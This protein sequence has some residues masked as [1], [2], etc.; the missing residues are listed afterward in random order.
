MIKT[1]II[2]TGLLPLLMIGCVTS[3]P[4]TGQT[5]AGSTLK[6]DTTRFV[7]MMA[8]AQEKCDLIDSIDTEIIKINPVGTGKTPASIKYGS[9]EE[10]WKVN[11]CG[12]QVPY[13]VTF[14]PDGNGGTYF[15]TAREK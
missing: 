14:T 4:T 5:A 13:L 15:S 7:T 12:K 9:S 10:R 2:V 1:K 3:T 6:K 11:L 8:K